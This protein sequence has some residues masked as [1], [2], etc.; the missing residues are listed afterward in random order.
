VGGA[1]K[2]MMSPVVGAEHA[3]QGLFTGNPNE[4]GQGLAGMS[5]MGYI[6]GNSQNY[7]NTGHWGPT[8]GNSSGG[9][10]LSTPNINAV[11]SGTSSASAS[12]GATNTPGKV[13]PISSGAATPVG[14]MSAGQKGAMS[15]AA[16]GQLAGLTKADSGSGM[17]GLSAAT[18]ANQDAWASGYT[19]QTPEI[20]KIIEGYAANGAGGN[21]ATG[22]I[23]PQA[24][25]TFLNGL[26]GGS[27][28]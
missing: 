13:G 24:L 19:N 25:Q 3:T 28:G 21:G 4:I 12:S 23:S 7:A 2:T 10:G 22:L 17:N 18:L 8:G 15:S 1:I 14:G 27:N 16:L 9:G 5:G 26:G 11:P 6:P 20:Q